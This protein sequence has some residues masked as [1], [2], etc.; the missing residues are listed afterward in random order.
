MDPPKF[1]ENKSQLMGACRGYKDIN[2][3]A[4]QLLNEGGILLTFS[5]SGL[6]TS[7]LFQKI[8]ADA[9]IDAVVMYNL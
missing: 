8:I 6:M 5:C 3:L 1:V 2:M 7:D 9:A 4:I